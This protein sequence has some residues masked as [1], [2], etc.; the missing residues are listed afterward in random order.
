ML[1]S[2]V[3]SEMCIRDRICH[4]K[5]RNGSSLQKLRKWLADNYP[6]EASK[7]T[8]AS[9]SLKEIKKLVDSGVLIK[10]KA[11]YKITED[12]KVAMK[13]KERDQKEAARR[14]LRGL[15]GGTVAQRKAARKKAANAHLRMM[16]RESR[17]EMAARKLKFNQYLTK[18]KALILPFLQEKENFYARMERETFLAEYEAINSGQEG[19]EATL[20]KLGMPSGNGHVVTL[21]G[22]QLGLP[23]LELN[24]QGQCIYDLNDQRIGAMILQPGSEFNLHTISWPGRPLPVGVTLAKQ[25]TALVTWQYVYWL[26]K[27]IPSGW[28]IPVPTGTTAESY[29]AALRMGTGEYVGLTKMVLA[30]CMKYA[31][32]QNIPRNNL[33]RMQYRSLEGEMVVAERPF[34]VSQW[35]SL[36]YRQLL[37]QLLVRKQQAVLLAPQ[38][39]ST[40]LQPSPEVP[41]IIEIPMPITLSGPGPPHPYQRQ[42]ISWLVSMYD[43]AVGCILAD[44][45]GLG[46][47]LQTIGLIAHLKERH[48]LVSGP[49]LIVGPLS[50]LANWMSELATWC[51]SLRAVKFHGIKDERQRLKD[52]VLIYGKFDVCVTT[53]EQFISEAHFFKHRFI[54]DCF[55]IDEGHRLKNEKSLLAVN[56]RGVPCKQRV[57]LT[58]TP[59]QN[60]LRE[61]WALLHFLL[62]DVFVAASSEKF[63]DAFD[64]AKGKC[65]TEMLRRAHALLGPIMIMRKKANVAV[66]LPPKTEI[67]LRVPMCAL[68]R[69]WYSRLLNRLSSD[70]LSELA[71]STGATVTAKPAVASD[72]AK[73][74]PWVELGK[75]ES[76]RRVVQIDGHDVI[77]WSNQDQSAANEIK[78]G[79]VSENGSAGG[80]DDWNKLMN[81]VMQLRKVCNHPYLISGCIESP[82]ALDEH[83]ISASGKLAVLDVLFR[84]LQAAGHRVL[85]FS[86]F[87][88]MLDILEDFCRYRNIL[89][90]R[91]DGSTNRIQRRLDNQ[92]FNHPD[93][94]LSCYLISTRAGGLG[95]NLATADTVILY[96][97]DWNPQVDEQAI[98]RAHRIG[99]KKPVTV[100]RFVAESSV[101]ERMVQFAEKKLFLSDMVTESE[102]S[103]AM[104]SNIGRAELLSI[105]GT[106]ASEFI[107]DSD[108]SSA[109]GFDASA[110]DRTLGGDGTNLSFTDALNFRA[111]QQVKVYD[112]ELVKQNKSA[113]KGLS[114]ELAEIDT[115]SSR[116]WIHGT[117]CWICKQHRCDAKCSFC[118]KVYHINCLGTVPTATSWSCPVHRCV[119]CNRSTAAA[120]GLLFRCLN[121]VTSY[122]ED[123][124]PEDQIETVGRDLEAEAA[125]Y[126]S[127]QAYYIR[128]GPCSGNVVDT[129]NEESS[130][131]G[132]DS[133]D[134]DCEEDGQDDDDMMGEL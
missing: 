86:Q 60:N 118:P 97:S 96:D 57:L 106:G 111:L 4:L 66:T 126:I 29:T 68:Q 130:M 101:E 32:R 107:Q 124:L 64:L 19:A 134:E 54:W 80:V 61:L 47:T 71:N 40:D 104:M 17:G 89:Y 119:A 94:M 23:P 39:Q 125:G 9:R 18:Y 112:K 70:T 2:L 77:R 98:D 55:V 63:E 44:E 59:L 22:G 38:H 110:I 7:N 16:N 37:R 5:E 100:Y 128:C 12:A 62:P 67:K 28:G 49:H 21:M 132:E 51:P 53:Y 103:S 83:M 99:Q 116:K 85:I 69:M 78:T 36:Q 46:K 35:F 10:I 93:S 52:E 114:Q 113:T 33:I 82:Y 73:E 127:K 3:G 6:E 24:A 95:I 25:H 91:L 88:S 75:R 31:T 90:S 76:I 87:T 48:P 133:G 45:M 102:A 20:V 74:E 58:G 129:N 122:C 72:A 109:P 14:K 115:G 92:R 105:L 81:T 50:V 121:C 11:S 131:A 117:H 13:Q 41:A 123:C 15:K 1:R 65:D 8:F 30:S 120:G 27:P 84:R 108:H 43:R 34:C 79:K 26:R 42:G 56:A